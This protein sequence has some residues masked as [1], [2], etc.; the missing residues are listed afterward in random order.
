MDRWSRTT[1]NCSVGRD[2]DLSCA[3][4][5]GRPL[6]LLPATHSPHQGASSSTSPLP[7]TPTG[8]PSTSCP[9]APS[10]TTSQHYG[11]SPTVPTTP[12][13]R[14]PPTTILRT[15]RMRTAHSRRDRYRVVSSSSRTTR[16]C[17]SRPSGS[18]VVLDPS[19]PPRSLSSATR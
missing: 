2:A 14:T 15:M 7:S 4:S 16:N 8:S 5:P 11:S 10:P 12:L 9:V 1:R 6:P 3:A 18:Y 17:P 13:P 19:R